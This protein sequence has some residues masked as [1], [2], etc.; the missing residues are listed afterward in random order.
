MDL[1]SLHPLPYEARGNPAPPLKQ[2]E[3]VIARQL[4]GETGCWFGYIVGD[5][6][7]NI[8]SQSGQI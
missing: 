1:G 7:H 8:S 6:A 3:L 4:F 5:L 2:V